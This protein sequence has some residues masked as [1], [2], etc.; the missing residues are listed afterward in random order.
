MTPTVFVPALRDPAADTRGDI[1][2]L[3]ERVRAT[4]T[5]GDF[6]RIAKG[7]VRGSGECVARLGLD[8]GEPVLDVACGTGNVSLPA[9]RIGAAVTGID[10]APNLVAQAKARAAA[11]GLTIRCDVGDAENMPYADGAFHTAISTFGIMF[12]ARPERAA[13]EILRVVR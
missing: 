4:W 6:G 10:I 5:A 13:A 12:A 11:E 3:T 9:A 2:P 8:Q 7:Y 1:D